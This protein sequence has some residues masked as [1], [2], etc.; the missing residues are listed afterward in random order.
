[1]LVE[2]KV[3]VSGHERRCGVWSGVGIRVWDWTGLDAPDLEKWRKKMI[4][5]NGILR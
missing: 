3:R 2:S 5:R 4:N 1:M